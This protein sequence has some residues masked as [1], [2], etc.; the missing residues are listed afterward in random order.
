MS[1]VVIMVSFKAVQLSAFR[2]GVGTNGLY[3]CAPIPIQKDSA[4]PQISPNKAPYVCITKG[5]VFASQREMCLHYKGKFV[6]IT[7]GNVF[8]LQREMPYYLHCLI[9][10]QCYYCIA[11]I[12]IKR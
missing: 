11:V 7:K 12:T 4:N 1:S 3:T 9:I 5:N 6:C 10:T 8:A 2:P